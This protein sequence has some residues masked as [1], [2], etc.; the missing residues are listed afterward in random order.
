MAPHKASL[1]AR[2]IGRVQGVG[3]R[4]FTERVAQGTGVAG[5]VMNC[6]DG[7]VEV[8]AE[9]E[10]ETLEELLILLKQGPRGARVERVEETWGS[11]T[12]RFSGFTVRFGV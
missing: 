5:Y 11:Y 2:V 6:H 4:Y 1:K 7:S 3:F 8:I 10:R 12:G 9:G